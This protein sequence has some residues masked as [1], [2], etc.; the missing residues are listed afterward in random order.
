MAS[1]NQSYPCN[2]TLYN[3]WYSSILL[4]AN[5]ILSIE[6]LRK[7]LLAI[8]RTDDTA[9]RI[10]DFDN[11]STRDDFIELYSGRRPQTL[12]IS[13]GNA[14]ALSTVWCKEELNGIWREIAGGHG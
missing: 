2:T 14:M 11:G 7:R 6:R 8:D 12:E 9:W 5:D 4:E 10:M 13:S 3:E 1:A